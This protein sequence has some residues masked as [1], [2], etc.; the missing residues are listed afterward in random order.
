MAD[1]RE[2]YRVERLKVPHDENGELDFAKAETAVVAESDDAE[3]A[4]RY[5]DGYASGRNDAD[6]FASNQDFAHALFYR[7]VRVPEWV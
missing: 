3:D 5:W 4:L 1:Y 7:V 2:I 6:G